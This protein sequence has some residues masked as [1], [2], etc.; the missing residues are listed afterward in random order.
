LQDKEIET[1]F[2]MAKVVSIGRR[3]RNRNRKKTKGSL[4]I[5]IIIVIGLVIGLLAL[6]GLMKIQTVVI[7]GNTYYSDNQILQIA[8]I[9]EN[10]S[11][12]KLRLDKAISLEAYP[13]IESMDIS[14]TGF[15]SVLVKVQEKE[16]VGFLPYGDTGFLSIDRDG[17][18]IE[19]LD[20]LPEDV[21]L[22]KGISV[23]QFILGEKIELDKNIIKTFL[24]FTRGKNQ[25][26]LDISE[27]SFTDGEFNA[28]TFYIGDLLVE[29]GNMDNFNDKMQK[30]QD[31]YAFIMSQDKRI[32]DVVHNTLK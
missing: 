23:N 19:Y 12:L 28:V 5:L 3:R 26:E 4:L 18:V 16:V 10:T 22:I 7:E 29:F 14:Y 30:I 20:D 27:I 2:N 31:A 8:G 6:I 17:I 9:D 25:Y 21:I 24:Q 11:I 1:R 13:Y 15:D 32:Y